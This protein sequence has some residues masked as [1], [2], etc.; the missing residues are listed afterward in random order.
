MVGNGSS[1]EIT[2]PAE[3]DPCPPPS[4]PAVS[5][6][7]PIF[8]A[9]VICSR[10]AESRESMALRTEVMEEVVRQAMIIAV[11]RESTVTTTSSGVEGVTSYGISA[12]RAVG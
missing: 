4:P 1:D 8:S 12:K 6:T 7:R 2:P 3:H 11:S 5:S 9:P 10:Y